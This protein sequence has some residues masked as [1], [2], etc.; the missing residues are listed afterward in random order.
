M[1]KN[2]GLLLRLHK[3]SGE[4]LCKDSVKVIQRLEEGREI[5]LYRVQD[6]ES[7]ILKIICLL[8]NERYF[9]TG[10]A[11][12]EVTTDLLVSSADFQEGLQKSQQ[13]NYALLL[14]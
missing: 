8:S 3:W 12:T 1:P 7:C 4:L 10:V 11:E 6:L 2:D 9:A 14:I 5:V 13:F